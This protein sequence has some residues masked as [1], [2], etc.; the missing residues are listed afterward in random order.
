MLSEFYEKGDADISIKNMTLLQY[1]NTE[2]S[3]QLTFSSPGKISQSVLE[4]DTLIVEFTNIL[5]AKDFT[6]INKGTSL[7]V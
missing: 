7:S 4:S 3:I 6:R 1:E 2:I 5:M